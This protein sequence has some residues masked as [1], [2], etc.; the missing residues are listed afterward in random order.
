MKWLAAVLL[1]SAACQREPVAPPRPADCTSAVAVD[2]LHHRSELTL[3]PQAG[4]LTGSGTLK[5]RVP[6][7]ARGIALDAHSLRITRAAAGASALAVQQHEGRVC[8]ALPLLLAAG[9]TLELLRVAFEAVS[10]RNLREWFER[11]VYAAAP[12]L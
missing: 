8:L 11:W 3:R 5:V 10:G 4:A 12:D 2:V 9:S 6:V 1:L 7:A